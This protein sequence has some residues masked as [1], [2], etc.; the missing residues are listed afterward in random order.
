MPE[1]DMHTFIQYALYPY[2][3][4]ITAASVVCLLL[5]VAAV[6][7]FVKDAAAKR[8]IDEDGLF[9]IFCFGTYYGVLVFGTL[10]CKVMSANI[11][12]TDIFSFRP[13]FS[14]WPWRM[15]FQRTGVSIMRH[16]L[17]R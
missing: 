16:L 11:M 8:K 10:V 13:A 3:V 7:L 17:Q 1:I 14:G 9:M 2:T 5:A 6:L 15:S 4:G 12:L